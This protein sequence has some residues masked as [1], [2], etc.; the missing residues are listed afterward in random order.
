[1]P[2]MPA[3]YWRKRRRTLKERSAVKTH[4]EGV[5]EGIAM[6]IKFCREV[7]AGRAYTG[8]QVAIQIDKAMIGT[9]AAELT[10]R[11]A[12]VEALRASDAQ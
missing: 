6:C 10:Q 3:E 1:M 8:F 2:S 5:R 7:I 11:R 12:A 9:E 4:H